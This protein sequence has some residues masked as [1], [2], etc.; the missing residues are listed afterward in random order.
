LE[1]VM[2]KSATMLPAEKVICSTPKFD[3][4]DAVSC[5]FTFEKFVGGFRIRCCCDDSLDC[6]DMQSLC[7]AICNQGCTCCCVRDGIQVC[8]FNLCCAKCKCENIEGGCSI[9]CS[10]RDAKCCDILGT[11]CECLE[12]CCQ[13]SCCCYICF[14]NKCCCFGSCDA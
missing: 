1:P 9:T 6:S 5:E 2:N 8:S 4:Q 3:M 11:I 7:D 13:N 12:T 10:S 14:G